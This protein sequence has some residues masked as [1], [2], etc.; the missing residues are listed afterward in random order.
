MRHDDH[1]HLCEMRKKRWITRLLQELHISFHSWCHLHFS[2]C[3]L[4]G[5]RIW[6]RKS[7]AHE[8][9]PDTMIAHNSC[10]KKWNP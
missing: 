5:R 1:P 2:R 10:A 9:I 8:V 4:C 3:G 7:Y 6:W